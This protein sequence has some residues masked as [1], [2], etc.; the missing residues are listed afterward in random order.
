VEVKSN[1]RTEVQDTRPGWLSLFGIGE[2]RE[3]VSTVTWTHSSSIEGRS[4]QLIEATL[5]VTP[6]TPD[7]P[8]YLD[9]YYDR[10]FGALAFKE[11]PPSLEIV[12]GV[13]KDADGRP[14]SGVGVT[15]TIGDQKLATY[16]TD[17]QGRYSIR[18]PDLKDGPLTLTIGTFRKEL[19]YRG[20]AIRGVDFKF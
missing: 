20:A 8:Y 12:S 13:V 10:I 2:D 7:T 3:E 15:A 18:V 17:S 4:G 19:D 5:Q 6:D 11:P 1:F 14:L 9:I 16:K